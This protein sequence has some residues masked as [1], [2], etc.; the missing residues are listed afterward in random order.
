MI[1]GHLQGK[2]DG[3]P[4]NDTP[5]SCIKMSKIKYRRSDELKPIKNENL[6]IYLTYRTIQTLLEA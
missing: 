5:P 4:S 1:N 6:M 3:H 2:E